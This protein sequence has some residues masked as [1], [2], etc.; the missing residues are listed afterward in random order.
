MDELPLLRLNVVL[1]ERCQD[2]ECITQYEAGG[3]NGVMFHFCCRICTF[4]SIY[5]LHT[6]CCMSLLPLE[7]INQLLMYKDISF[8]GLTLRPH[9]DN[10]RI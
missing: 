10:T 4:V 6:L 8:Y 9:P 1:I 7:N 5:S 3:H 2:T